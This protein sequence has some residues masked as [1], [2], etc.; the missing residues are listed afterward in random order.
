MEC[1]VAMT[2]QVPDGT[3]ERAVDDIRARE[4]ARSRGRATYCGCGGCPASRARWA[5]G[6]PGT[7]PRCRRS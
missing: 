5:C 4:A 1:L 6:T 3:P 2:T 7:P